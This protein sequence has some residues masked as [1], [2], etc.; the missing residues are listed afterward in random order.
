M[1]S[2]EAFLSDSY[3]FGGFG[4]S[5]LPFLRAPPPIPERSDPFSERS[6]GIKPHDVSLS[7]AIQSLSEAME[8]DPPRCISERSDGIDSTTYL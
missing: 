7:E 4:G 1:R 2:T 8:L 5:A 6:D 3:R